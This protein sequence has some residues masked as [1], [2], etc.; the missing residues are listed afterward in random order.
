MNIPDK[1]VYLLATVPL[2]LI[3]LFL[4][5]KRKDLRREILLIGLL[6]GIA[7]V[8]T[9]YFW[10]TKDWWQPL[11]ITGTT[12]GIEDFITG[13]TSGGIMAVIY[14]YVF[15]KTYKNICPPPK[16][17]SSFFVLLF[18]L[19]LTGYLFSV[20]GITSFWAIT[21]SL[22]LSIAFIVFVRE[23]LFYN[24]LFS[25]LAMMVISIL[26]YLV[27]MYV[28]S[29]WIDNTYLDGLSGLRFLNVPVEEFIFWFLA[30]MWAG[31]FYEY[32]GGKCY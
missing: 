19:C 18:L 13:F 14:S 7:S 6:G 30:G 22:V 31:P 29:T 9:S 26:S 32:A 28:S 17:V 27:I 23:D 3:W 10:W 16:P 5:I 15:G 4:F 1:Y 20:I 8:L 12:V 24:A 11:T 2:F 21:I 25:G